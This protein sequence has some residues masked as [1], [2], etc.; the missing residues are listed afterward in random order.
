MEKEQIQNNL[1]PV[2]ED[3]VFY[4]FRYCLG[5]QTYCVSDCV[6]YLKSIWNNLSKQTRKL[7]CK[8]INTFLDDDLLSNIDAPLWISILEIESKYNSE[9]SK[10]NSEKK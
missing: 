8:E 10:Y 2:T 6:E 7:I 1:L 5:R 4:A 9:E 3:M